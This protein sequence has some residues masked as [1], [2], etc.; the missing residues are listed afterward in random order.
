MVAGAVAAFVAAPLLAI[1]AGAGLLMTGI[2]LPFMDPARSLAQ[3]LYSRLKASPMASDDLESAAPAPESNISDLSSD[4]NIQE[5]VPGSLEPPLS[6][7]AAVR[8]S[9]RRII[10]GGTVTLILGVIAAAGAKMLGA[11]TLETAVAASPAASWIGGLIVVTA[12][13][14]P[15]AL[16]GVTVAILG[17]HFL[18]RMIIPRPESARV[19]PLGQI[20]ENA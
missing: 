4:S 20:L 11:A 8:S 13:Y 10:G 9:L 16:L 17:W 5:L 1:P 2:G 3:S 18:Y 7:P 19:M 15:Y 14:L 6:K 12:S